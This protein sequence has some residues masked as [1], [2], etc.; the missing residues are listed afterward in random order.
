MRMKLLEQKILEHGVA[1]NTHVLLVDTFLN[2]QVDVPLMQALG[3]EF[4]R[5][6]KDKGIT[7]VATIESSGIAPATFTALAMGLPMVILK[8]SKSS[9]LSEEISQT[10]VESFTKGLTYQLTLKNKFVDK[11]DNV[12]I[13]D[14]FLAI[15]E[16]AL[17]AIRLIEMAGAH[18]GGVG[19]VIE[20]A[21]QPGRQRLIDAG[22]RP[23]SLA[24]VSKMDKDLIEF[25]SEEDL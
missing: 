11:Q 3:A 17:G 7:R 14:D 19:I 22:H 4:A 24:R 1:L 10:P 8:K 2:H 21:F 13:I 12:L 18:V 5:I 15:G 6:Y 23:Y 25:V 20:K 16:A 9:I